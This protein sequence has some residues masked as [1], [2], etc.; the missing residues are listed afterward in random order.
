MIESDTANGLFVFDMY[1][2]SQ[3][4]REDID[5]SDSVSLGTIKG[6][7]L[8]VFAVELDETITTLGAYLC[9]TFSLRATMADPNPDPAVAAADVDVTAQM[10]AALLAY[11]FDVQFSDDGDTWHDAPFVPATDAYYRLRP[12][13]GGGSAAWT[14]AIGLPTVSID[15]TSKH[16][17]INGVDTGIVAEGQD[18][19]DG[20]TPEIGL[21]GNWYI[22]GVDTGVKAQGQDG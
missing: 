14:D 15:G 1:Y 20:D 22:G 4:L 13:A 3:K 17:I 18:G 7:E 19:V 10:I 2:Y 9:D 6:L 5:Y 12:T 8:L 21:N 11:G 16:W